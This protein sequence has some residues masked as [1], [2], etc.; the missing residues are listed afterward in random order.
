MHLQKSDLAYSSCSTCP[1]CR[2][3]QSIFWQS[4][5]ASPGSTVL[6][7]FKSHQ[8]QCRETSKILARSHGFACCAVAR[9]GLSAGEKQASR[10]LFLLSKPADE[11]RAF[12]EPSFIVGHRC[13]RVRPVQPM[14]RPL[15]PL[16][17]NILSGGKTTLQ[18]H[19]RCGIHAAAWSSSC[20]GGTASRGAMAGIAH[21]TL[22]TAYPESAV[23]S[24]P[25]LGMLVRL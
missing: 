10:F 23:G 14:T 22:A 2:L 25:Y 3:L 7:L 5:L 9:L 17:G 24:D 13:H 19:A 6:D 18:V 8:D 12:R 4:P 1:T 15:K 11:L 20:V 21:K 16:C